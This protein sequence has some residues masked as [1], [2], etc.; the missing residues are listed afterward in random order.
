MLI[1]TE[2]LLTYNWLIHSAK[3]S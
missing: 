3:T 2:D 1:T